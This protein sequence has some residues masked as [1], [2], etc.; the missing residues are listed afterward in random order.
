MVTYDANTAKCWVY[1]FKEGLLSPIAHDLKHRVTRFTL[2][3]DPEQGAVEAEIDAQ[4]L[5]VECVMKNG[6]ES[7]GDELTGDDMEE[8]EGQVV[9]DVLHADQHPLI[10]FRSTAVR[11]DAEGLRI[12]GDMVLNARTRP[13]VGTVRRIGDEYFAE[14][15]INQPQFGIKPFSAMMGALKIKPDVL[16]RVVVPAV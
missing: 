5:R 7:D 2:R 12:E 10:R 13:V 16:V 9:K 6:R 1:S 3:I 11:R 15:T 8:I 14:M 4:S